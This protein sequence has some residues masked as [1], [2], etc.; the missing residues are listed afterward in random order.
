MAGQMKQAVADVV[1][2][3]VCDDVV[4]W[5]DVLLESK[6]DVNDMTKSMPMRPPYPV[7]WLEMA[8]RLG[9]QGNIA[10]VAVEIR[11]GEVTA[12][13]RAWRMMAAKRGIT[14]SKH[15]TMDGMLQG[16]NAVSLNLFLGTQG[17]S[18]QEQEA[19]RAAP[20]KPRF[21]GSA[22]TGCDE[23][24]VRK[25]GW[26]CAPVGPPGPDGEYTLQSWLGLA[27][28][29]LSL[30]HLKNA[31]VVPFG[32]RAQ[33]KQNVRGPLGVVVRELV[34]APLRRTIRTVR[35]FREE[36]PGQPLPAH[37]RRGH[38]KVFTQ[39]RPL[40]GKHVGA[41]WWEPCWPGSEHM[42]I[43]LH[44]RARIAV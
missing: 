43:V 27:R 9:N 32:N 10:P 19:R 17:A 24:W 30:F 34:I 8:G 35:L 26:V 3:I 1:M 36:N 22:I 12:M 2:P 29:A 40:L 14:E 16:V 38:F 28:H 25:G 31:E 23:N 21:A 41:Y 18:Q 4:E 39:A 11:S 13:R 42:G 7:T 44:D 37:Y 33:R 5:Y 20:Q 6:K 15:L